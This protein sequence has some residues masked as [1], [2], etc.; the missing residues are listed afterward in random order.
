MSSQSWSVWHW[1]SQSVTSAFR[2]V[3]HVILIIILV[4]DMC[5]QHFTVGYRGVGTGPPWV[6][7]SL[8]WVSHF[9]GSVCLHSWRGWAWPTGWTRWWRST[10]PPRTT[11]CCVCSAGIWAPTRTEWA[12]WWARWWTTSRGQFTQPHCLSQFVPPTSSRVRARLSVTGS[13]IAPLLMFPLRKL[14]KPPILLL[15]HW[16]PQIASVYN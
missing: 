1:M 10:R 15:V 4:S 8:W 14:Q 9:L 3:F 5:E 11:S 12:S 13:V 16:G 7:P 2:L 6:R